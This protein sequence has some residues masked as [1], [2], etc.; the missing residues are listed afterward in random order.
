M[1]QANV[2][3]LRRSFEHM[4]A[5]GEPQWSVLDGQLEVHDHDILDAGDY[6]GHAGFARWLTDFGS[7]WS[8]FSFD[9]QELID[10]GDSVVAVLAVRATGRGSGVTAERRDGMVCRMRDAVVVRIDYY[11]SREQALDAVGLV[12]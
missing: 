6:R 3:V 2:D 8:E 7:V 9:V 4:A 5:T 11:N 12:E 10:A 1:S